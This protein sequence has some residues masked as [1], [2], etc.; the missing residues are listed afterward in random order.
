MKHLVLYNEN[1]NER[2]EFWK[3]KLT[4]PYYDVKLDKI[5]IPENDMKIFLRDKEKMLELENL[6]YINIYI[7]I[8][9]PSEHIYEWSWSNNFHDYNSDHIFKGNVKITDED[10]KNWK[11][12]QTTRKYNL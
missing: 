9:H 2:R 11:I 7:G 12:K 10:I 6:P 3:F 1:F 8:T 4:D 5:G